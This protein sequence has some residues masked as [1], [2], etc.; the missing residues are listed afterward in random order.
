MESADLLDVIGHR[1]GV[2]RVIYARMTFVRWRLESVLC[3]TDSVS[4]PSRRPES[5]LRAIHSPC[6]SKPLGLVTEWVRR[7][8]HAAF[9]AAAAG[10]R[11]MG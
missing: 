3:C 1:G 9:G 8:L 6:D 11:Q 10:A 2:G 5:R 7:L 4:C